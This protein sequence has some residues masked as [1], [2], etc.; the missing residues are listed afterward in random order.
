MIQIDYYKHLDSDSKLTTELSMEEIAEKCC[1]LNYGAHRLLSALVHVLRKR[2]VEYV[3]STRNADAVK[4]QHKR[5][6]LPP[7]RER[8]PL[9][10]AIESALNAGH[11]Y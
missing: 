10:D 11:Y 5:L 7:E 9:A 6:N 8:S 3:Q 1:E 2:N 4:P